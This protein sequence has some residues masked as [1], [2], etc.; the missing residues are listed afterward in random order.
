MAVAMYENHKPSDQFPFKENEVIKTSNFVFYR[1]NRFT[2]NF[3][4][5][6][7]DLKMSKYNFRNGG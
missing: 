7:H 5:N 3:I 6:R 2:K 1:D 4:N